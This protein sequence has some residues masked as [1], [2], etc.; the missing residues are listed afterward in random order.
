MALR[1]QAASPATND[2]LP[3]PHRPCSC[4]RCRIVMCAWLRQAY[5]WYVDS[6]PPLGDI[7]EAIMRKIIT[8]LGLSAALVLGLASPALAV[9]ESGTQYCSAGYTPMAE[10][11]A[12][13]NLYFK[14]PGDAY[15]TYYDLGD[16]FQ[17]RSNGGPGGYWRAYISGYGGLDNL[18]TYSHCVI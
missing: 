1:A 11:L 14:G 7:T 12:Y 2:S 18:G 15:Y 8:T 9:E 5:G 17:R 10:A 16:H 6:V 4:R 13:G 3:P